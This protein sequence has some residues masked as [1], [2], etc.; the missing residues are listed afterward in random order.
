MKKLT[1]LLLTAAA[2]QLS[3][4]TISLTPSTLNPTVGQTFTIDV[5]VD[6]NG[7][8]E[9]YAAG[10]D[11]LISVVNRLS[12]VSA[13]FNPL[14]VSQTVAGVDVYGTSETLT[15]ITGNSFTLATLTLQAGPQAGLVTFSILSDTNSP[16]EGLFSLDPNTFDFFQTDLDASV[17]LDVQAVP[18]PASLSMLALAGAALVF[19]KRRKSETPAGARETR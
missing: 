2:I 3:A 18:E 13:M 19:L 15:N 4:A 11:Y 6:N 8:D 10:F 12:F 7:D 1:A 5:L 14:F 17:Q 16:D 9:V